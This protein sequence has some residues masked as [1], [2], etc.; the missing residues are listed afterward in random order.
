VPSHCPKIHVPL[1]CPKIH[2]P[3]HCPKIH[4]AITLPKNTC[5]HIVQKYMW[6]PPTPFLAH[7]YN[8]VAPSRV[9]M[10]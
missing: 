8:A 9:I 6:P 1:H 4:V 7:D 3:V 2:V 10:K 5:G